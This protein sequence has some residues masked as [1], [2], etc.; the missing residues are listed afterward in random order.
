MI[1]CPNANID[2]VNISNAGNALSATAAGINFLRNCSHFNVRNAK[3][4]GIKA[5]TVGPD[6]YIHSFGIGV[7]SAGNG[8]SQHGNIVN[9]RIND[10]DGYNSGDVKPDGDGIYLIERPTDDFSGDGYINI[11]RC[12]IK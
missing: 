6:G 8:Y 11:S 3:I 1:N 9:V 5:G 12:E 7:T 4:S 2:N 10:I